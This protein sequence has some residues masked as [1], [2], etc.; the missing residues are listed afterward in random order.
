MEPLNVSE[1]KEKR[2]N[3]LVT[4][5]EEVH[6][7]IRRG[8]AVISEKAKS[9]SEEVKKVDV[10]I[11]QNTNKLEKGICPKCQGELQ[12]EAKFCSKC[13]FA[14]EEHFAMY[15]AHC[16]YCNTPMQA[17]Q[18]YCSVCGTK[19]LKAFSLEKAAE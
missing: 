5:G 17:E 9:L 8:D 14:V 3:L 13:G 12:E 1:L 15:V 16:S 10:Q 2:L 6:S 4:L 18:N 7:A 11:G 19:Q